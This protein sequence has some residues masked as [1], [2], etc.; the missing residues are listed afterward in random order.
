[1]KELQEGVLIGRL[2][3]SRKPNH[4]AYLITV[5]YMNGVG[6]VIKMT[7]NH[8]KLILKSLI[9][10]NSFTNYQYNVHLFQH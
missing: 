10:K 2:Y 7:W 6:I 1:M 9:Q 5:S 4:N 8:V 3:G